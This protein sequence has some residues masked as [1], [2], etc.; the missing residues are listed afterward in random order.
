MVE[1]WV[2]MTAGQTFTD[3]ASLMGRYMAANFTKALTEDLGIGFL[4]EIGGYEPTRH[5]ARH[6]LATPASAAHL[7]PARCQ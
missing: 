3:R 1:T 7:H 5:F 6:R 4:T 2:E